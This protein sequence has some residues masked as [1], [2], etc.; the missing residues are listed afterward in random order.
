[1]AMEDYYLQ[2]LNS[3]APKDS[4]SIGKRMT[5]HGLWLNDDEAFYDRNKAFKEKVFEIINERSAKEPEPMSEKKYHLAQEDSKRLNEASYLQNCV[6][7]VLKD[8]CFVYKE[9]DEDPQYVD[10]GLDAGI[11]PNMDSELRGTLLPHRYM[12]LDFEREMTLALKKADNMK[13]AK[14]D[15]AYGI[16]GRKIPKL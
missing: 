3:T 13:N 1:M 4:D 14:P 12:Y 9:G 16:A 15:Y 10:F 5:E 2:F 7:I 6:P 8:G 11:I